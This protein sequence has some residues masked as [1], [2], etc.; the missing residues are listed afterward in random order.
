MS[1]KNNRSI[2]ARKHAHDITRESCFV[3]LRCT[4]TAVAHIL[5]TAVLLH[6]P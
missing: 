6:L 1:K 2:I 5:A 4:P 3:A